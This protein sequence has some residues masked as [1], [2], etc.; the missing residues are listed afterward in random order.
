MGLEKPNPSTGKVKPTN[1]ELIAMFTGVRV[2]E[3]D[4]R[5]S[6]SYRIS[7]YRGKD[8]AL[9]RPTINYENTPEGIIEDYV[10]LE[11][12]RYRNMQNFYR[13][14]LAT[15]ELIGLASTVR[16]LKEN[17]V[18]ENE[19]ASL[20]SGK[21]ANPRP[22]LSDA[23]LKNVFKKTPFDPKSELNSV[24]KLSNALTDEYVKMLNT[25][26][27]FEKENLKPDIGDAKPKEE[28]FRNFN[29]AKG[30]Q[31]YNVPKVPVEPDERIDKMTGLPYD[32]QAGEAFV[33]EEDRNNLENLFNQFFRV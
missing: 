7:E 33:D 8:N 19:M 22:P 13:Q 32:Q 12:Q 25:N 14:F 3:L 23:N 20:I 18:S 5:I 1:L 21:Y 28:E 10:N 2:T 26:L 27:Y 24:G 4:P 17:N 30:G 9:S 6:F 31:V 29:L 15:K 16:I 11:K